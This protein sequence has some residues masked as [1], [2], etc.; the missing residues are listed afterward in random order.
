MKYEI[1]EK[2]NGHVQGLY[3]QLSPDGKTSFDEAVR[4]VRE[5]NPDATTLY[6][7]R[8]LFLVADVKWWNTNNVQQ[9]GIEDCEK[10]NEYLED[11]E[12]DMIPNLVHKKEEESNG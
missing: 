5:N 1:D 3:K 12:N 10:I 4:W 9:L 11:H 7:F 8:A 6:I 2:P